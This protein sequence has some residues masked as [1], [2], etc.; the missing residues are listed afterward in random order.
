MLRNYLSIYRPDFP[1]VVVYMLQATEYQ[2]GPYLRWLWRTSDFSKVMHRKTLVM[3]KPAKLLLIT[4]YIG[5]LTQ[6]SLATVLGIWGI[7]EPV[8]GLPLVA[9]IL[10]FCAP[11]VWSHL[12]VLPLILGRMFIIR[13]SHAVQVRK[14][15]K[16]FKEHKALKIAV[17]GSYGKTTLKEMLLTVLSEGKKV[18]ATPANLNVPISHARFAKK[19][20]GD[21]DVLILE[22][23]EGAPGDIAKFAKVTKPDIGI[24]TG[25]APA[26]LDKY[27]TLQRAGED[28]FSLA[29]YLN[30]SDVYVNSESEA[31]Q[32]FVKKSFNT[33]D[34]KNAAGWAIGEIKVSLDG[35]SFEMKKG[36]K[37]LKAKSQLLGRHQVG[38][39]GVVAALADRLGLGVQQIEAGIS[40]IEPFEHRM[41]PRKTAGAWILDDTYNGN[42]DGMKAGLRLLQELPAKRKVYITP[43]LVDQGSE[44]AKIHQELGEAIASAKPHVVVLMKHSVTPNIQ[45]G[46]EANGYKGRLIIEDDPLDFYNNLDKFIAAG[47]LVMM[48]NDWPDQ[49]E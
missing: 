42:I 1:K 16:S 14:S 26:H 25:L 18:A 38:P 34:S 35:T 41:Q 49:Y 6:L 28:I 22:Y 36:D 30:P 12:I 20:S 4:L 27:K 46:L 44:S 33:Y 15:H 21:E 40:K 39:L 47:D 11:V 32:P 23:G 37:T 24:I 5:I 8:P 2:I 13:P 43:G 7:S 48:Q 17:A 9:L 10:F 19:L 29:Q 3:T 45:K 31:A